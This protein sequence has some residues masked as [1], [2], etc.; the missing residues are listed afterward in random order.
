ML[1]VWGRRSSS[2]VQAVMWCIG[3]LDLT[4]ERIDAGLI[5][6]PPGAF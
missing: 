3:E 6:G 1:K 5:Y 2:N 4:Y